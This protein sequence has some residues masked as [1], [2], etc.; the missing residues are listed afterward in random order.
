MS[1]LFTSAFTSKDFVEGDPVERAE[2]FVVVG[3]GHVHEIQEATS[4]KSKKVVFDAEKEWKGHPIYSKGWAPSDSDVIKKAEEALKN[5]SIVDFRI[6][7]VRN[8]GVDR[9]TEIALLKKGMDNARTNVMHS[10]AQ[11][12]LEDEENWTEGILRTNPKEDKRRTGRTA[13]DLSDDELANSS[14]S[15]NSGQ[16]YSYSNSVE[17]QAWVSKLEDGSVNPG[18]YTVAA[19]SNIYG[20]VADWNREHDDVDFSVEGTRRVAK[21]LLS[22][23]NKLQLRIFD[24]KM[25]TPELDKQSHTR[26][27]AIIFETVKNQYPLTN[28]IAEDS[29]VLKGWLKDVYTAAFD[30]WQWSVENVADFV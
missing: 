3:R 4:G 16:S 23:A 14:S 20:F 26:A 12:K 1:D 2:V 10:L 18:S 17:P 28:E 15:R 5:G 22:V 21:A 6:E 27:R 25:E 29:V 9:S 8:K 30:Q 7:T 13:A 24:G 19:L 11:I